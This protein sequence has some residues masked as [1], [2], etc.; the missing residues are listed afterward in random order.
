MGDEVTYGFA[1]GSKSMT[2]RLNTIERVLTRVRL[3][4]ARV[5][6]Q[7]GKLVDV[8]MLARP[9]YELPFATAATT[10]FSLSVKLEEGIPKYTISKGSIQDGTNGAAIDLTGIIEEEHI[11]IHGYVVIEADVDEFLEIKN[12]KVNMVSAYDETNEVRFTT[13]G[14]IRQDKIRLLI[15]KITL[16]EKGFPTAWQAL[17]SSVR[18][19]T[20]S[21]GG[22][23]GKMFEYAPTVASKI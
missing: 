22:A 8:E 19:V 2:N 11:A 16:D 9:S 23:V 15:G 14:Q 6:T 21:L 12:W 7:G 1:G 3:M 4:R 13:S 20:G 18:I 5:I 10:P 17:F